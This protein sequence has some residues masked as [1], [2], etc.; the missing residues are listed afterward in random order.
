MMW[1]M[2]QTKDK[3]TAYF[4]FVDDAFEFFTPC[5]PTNSVSYTAPRLPIPPPTLTLFPP[6]P[7]IPST[8]TTMRLLLR[9]T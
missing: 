6:S 4:G 2:K 9:T 7:I 5:R 8:T 3:W 1:S